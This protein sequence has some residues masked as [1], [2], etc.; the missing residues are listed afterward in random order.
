MATVLIMFRKV[1]STGKKDVRIFL[2]IKQNRCAMVK[3][4]ATLNHSC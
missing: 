4:N 1:C 3:F 2:L